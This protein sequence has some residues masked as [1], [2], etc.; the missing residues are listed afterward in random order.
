MS[1]LKDLKQTLK[2]MVK[3]VPENIDTSN[4]VFLCSSDYET[5]LKKYKSF[6]V[7]YHFLVP[8][9]NIYFFDAGNNDNILDYIN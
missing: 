6:D 5:P 4:Y 9:E 8:K 1:K 2:A 3:Q 7:Y